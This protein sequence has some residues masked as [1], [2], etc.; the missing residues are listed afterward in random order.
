MPF[1]EVIERA[2][3]G[4]EDLRS[5]QWDLDNDIGAW[6]RVRGG[7]GDLDKFGATFEFA[8]AGFVVRWD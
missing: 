8:N 7:S 3:G 2:D 5:L 1:R 4:T 6:V